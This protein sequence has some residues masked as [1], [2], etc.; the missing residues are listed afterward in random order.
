[1]IVPR[2]RRSGLLLLLPS[3]YLPQ[4]AKKQACRDPGSRWANFATRLRRWVDVATFIPPFAPSVERKGTL[5]K[6]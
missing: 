6:A 3:A 1:M 5:R 2:L 4:H